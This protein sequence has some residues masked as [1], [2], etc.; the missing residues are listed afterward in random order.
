MRGG[1]RTVV[2]VMRPSFFSFSKQG[3]HAHLPIRARQSNGSVNSKIAGESTQPE[4][5]KNKK[6]KLARSPQELQTEARPIA[7]GRERSQEKRSRVNKI[8]PLA[9]AT[10]VDE[11]SGLLLRSWINHTHN[12]QKRSE[13]CGEKSVSSA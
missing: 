8:L 13:Q 9:G 10:R 5:A 12:T 1:P 6:R 4:P 3:M 2:V 7:S 11:R